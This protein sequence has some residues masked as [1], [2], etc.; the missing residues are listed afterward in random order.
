MRNIAFFGSTGPR[1][2][3]NFATFAVMSR[4]S[5]SN[6][7]RS[8][9][10]AGLFQTNHG[11]L[12]FCSSPL[13]NSMSALT[14]MPSVAAANPSPADIAHLDLRQRERIL[15]SK[16]GITVVAALPDRRQVVADFLIGTAGAKQRAQVVSCRG[17]QARV[18]LA[19][20]R[21]P[22][23]RAIAAERLRHRRDDADFASAIGVAPALRDFSG[24]IGIDRLEREARCDC[25]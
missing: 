18:E 7:S 3:S 15:R 23:P 6:S 10:Y 22:R 16:L 14:C 5:A 17:E 8:T 24:I 13:R 25:S 21:Q 19:V 2:R 11:R 9:S 12:L 20:G 1:A 4:T